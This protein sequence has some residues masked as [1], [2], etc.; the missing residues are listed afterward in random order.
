MTDGTFHFQVNLGGML[1]VLSNHLYRSSDVFMREL[2]QNGADAIALRRDRQPEWAGG[3]MTITVDPGERI[4]FHDDG[5]GLDEEDIH[6]FL[7]VIGQSSKRPEAASIPVDYIGRFGIGLLSCFMVSDAI[8]VL[9]RRADGDQGY[10]WTGLPDGTYTIAPAEVPDAGTSVILEAKPGSERYFQ[11]GKV[12]RLV[13]HYAL[14]L[15]VPVRLEGEADPLNGLPANVWEGSRQQLLAFGEWLFEER[16]LEAIPIKTD[17]LEGVAFVVPYRVGS[18]VTDG[19]RIFLKRMLLTESGQT[20]LPSWAFFLRCVLNADGLQPTASREDLYE[21][22]DLE[23]AQKEFSKAVCDHLARLARRDPDRLSAIVSVHEDAIKA[24]A[25]WDEELFDLFIDHLSFET[26][27]GVL[28]GSALKEH[29]EGALV[30]SV[31][32]FKQLKPIFMAQG[33]LLICTGYASDAE[34]MARFRASF[35]PGFAELREDDMDVVL[36]EP[37]YDDWERSLALAAAADEALA[38]FDCRA[39]LRAFE[40]RELPT[41][42]VVGEQARFF[43]QMKKARDEGSSIFAGALSSMIQAADPASSAAT[44]YLNAWNPLIR[45]L[46]ATDD[47]LVLESAI[48]ILYVQALVAG[49]HGLSRV[50]MMAMT[51]ALGALVAA[52]LGKVV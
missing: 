24:M 21:D 30:S 12:A 52:G 31:A 27:E 22:E 20:L 51:D 44:L 32:R 40:P 18:T 9:T 37:A 3:Q 7:A 23:A 4:V 16:F 48:R 47:P 2:I 33:R 25:V 5:A 36:E 29:E 13:R 38:P 6:R 45:D 43:R 1:D 42:Y 14:A 15:P 11:P 34:L 39:Q 50:E 19:H 49:G 46:F 41:L 17:H 26:S 10:A 28:T 8:R 35:A